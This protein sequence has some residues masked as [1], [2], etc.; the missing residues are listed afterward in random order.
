MITTSRFRRNRPVAIEIVGRGIFC[1]ILT[2]FCVSAYAQEY[3]GK[4]IKEVHV[5][6]LKRVSE[7]LVQSQLEV[8]AEQPFSQ[9]AISRDIRRLYDLSFFNS[10]KR[11]SLSN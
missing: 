6:G 3:E 10:I 11:C 4:T 5:Q 2:I 8:Q 9:L 1:A 7:H